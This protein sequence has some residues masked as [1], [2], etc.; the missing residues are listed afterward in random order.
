MRY[1]PPK[2]TAGL[3][4]SCVIG[5]RRSPLP[6]ASTIARTRF[7]GTGNRPLVLAIGVLSSVVL[8]VQR[9]G[10]PRLGGR[11]LVVRR[12]FAQIRGRGPIIKRRA[13]D[14]LRVTLGA[15]KLG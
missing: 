14:G 15:V 3:E 5:W 6:P 4:R 8:V 1:L 9:L 2:G 13:V 12:L 7:V 10:R 11:R